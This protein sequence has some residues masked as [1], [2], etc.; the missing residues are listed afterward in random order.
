MI[1]E[2]TS[3]KALHNLEVTDGLVERTL[4]IKNRQKN[5]YRL[6]EN[7]KLI[8]TLTVEAQE[9][10]QRTYTVKGK[11]DLRLVYERVATIKWF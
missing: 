5:L 6:Y 2:A 9:E 11:I 4:I 7:D 3:L 1:Y 10:V 8:D